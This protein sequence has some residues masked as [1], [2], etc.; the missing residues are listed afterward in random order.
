[1]IPFINRAQQVFAPVPTTPI[2][3]LPIEPALNMNRI[4]ADRIW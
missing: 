2:C 4:L 3:P 1:M